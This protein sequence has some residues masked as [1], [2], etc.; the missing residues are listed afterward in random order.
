MKKTV[1]IIANTI[2]LFL[3]LAGNLTAERRGIRVTAKSGKNLYLY[4]DYHALVVGIDDYDYWPNL[5][6]AVRDAMEVASVLKNVGMK[7]KLV[8]NPTSKELKRA[9]DELTYGVGK[10]ENRAILIYFSGHGETETLATGEKMGYIVPKDSPMP[11]KNPIG[12]AEKAISMNMIESYAL[13]IKSKHVLMVFDSCF[14]GTVFASL[15]GIPVGI[16]DK[17]SRP[18]RQFITAGSEN[19]EVPDD[20][21]FKTCF[22]QGI[23][24]EADYNEDG[25]VTG[26]ELGIYL[27]ISVVNYSRGAQHPQYG[28]IRHPKLDKG[29]FIFH[30]PD[31]SGSTGEK[32]QK[33]QD[34]LFSVES[35]RGGAKLFV[36]TKP[37]DAKV[38]VLNI[39]PKF[40]QGMVLEPGRYH[41]EATARGYEAKTMWT[42]LRA[43][44]GKRVHM[45]LDSVAAN[46]RLQKATRPSEQNG[47]RYGVKNKLE[48]TVKGYLSCLHAGKPKEISKF[49]CKEISQQLEMGVE[50]VRNKM[51]LILFDPM[52]GVSFRMAERAVKN[53]KI[54]FKAFELEV[55]KENNDSAIAKY[56]TKMSIK[57]VHP[58]SGLFVPIPD[59]EEINDKAY[60]IKE[61]GRWKLCHPPS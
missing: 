52:H 18:V 10:E 39:R 58:E 23:N 59:F 47:K 45:Q 40:F 13:R 8:I 51:T 31:I 46:K 43:S 9:F 41:I 17:S 61:M 60:F 14:S 36:I 12:F 21:I 3:F 4:K 27:D 7:V 5:Q 32:T 57:V 42:V 1:I 53:T 29:D 2:I 6:G 16:S 50:A 11:V 49:V 19:E 37:E 38:R 48:S 22:V 35:N 55:M 44:E 54:D 26:S 15:K 24:G 33:K 20:S 30:L 28:K 25:Y 34:A 56:S